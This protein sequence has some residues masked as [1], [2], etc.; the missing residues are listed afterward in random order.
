MKPRLYLAYE[1]PS[2]DQLRIEATEG[3]WITM[4]THAEV[5]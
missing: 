4:W 3:W 1:S 5:R 2:R